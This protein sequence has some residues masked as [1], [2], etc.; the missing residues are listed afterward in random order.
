[1]EPAAQAEKD[2]QKSGSLYGFDMLNYLGAHAAHAH[3]AHAAAVYA[4]THDGQQPL[5][6]AI[7]ALALY[8]R[9]AF[10]AL[11]QR[12]ELALSASAPADDDSALA[13]YINSLG[14]LHIRPR[15]QPRP[16]YSDKDSWIDLGLVPVD[17]ALAAAIN[18]HHQALLQQERQAFGVVRAAMDELS[19]SG[20]LSEVLEQVIDHVDHVE[21]V[22][23]YLDD[24]MFARIDR[25]VNLIDDK[26]GQGY[27]N[28]LRGQP[29]GEWSEGAVLMVAALHALFLSGRSVRF[30]EFNG[31]LLS[32]SALLE[33]LNALTLSYSKAE[34]DTGAEVD[35]E[36]PAADTLALF[37]LA[38][39]IRQQS[40]RATGKSWLRYRTIYG[41]NFM[42]HE[43][44]LASNTSTE[45]PRSYLAEFGADY[46]ELVSAEPG[47]DASEFI[48]M[49]QLASECL[50][51][52]V[53][54]IACDRGSAAV[55][56]WIEYLME[57]IVASAV[58]ATRSD[59]GMSSSLRDLAQ[60]VEY[61]EQRLVETIHGLTPAHF[62][63]CFVASDF[64]PRF[65]ADEGRTIAASVQKR[66][67][68]NRWHFIPG[69]L[70][71]TTIR[72]N[73]HWYYPP[74]VP[75]IAEHADVHR[76]AHARAMVKFSIRSPGPDMS[77]PPLQIAG[78][79]FRGFYDVRVVRM[80]GTPFN[81]DDILR[82]RRR[83]LWLEVVYSILSSYLMSDA[84]QNRAIQGF[85]VGD[86][87]DL[88]AGQSDA[89]DEAL[90]A[91]AL[92]GAR[93][94]AGHASL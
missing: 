4:L 87:L 31:A 3:S 60:M 25:F 62:F 19:R 94:A 74:L 15:S 80:D 36:A 20:E 67:M 56:S 55:T 88:P 13:L 39:H 73:R 18:G 54:G 17:A 59:Y 70:E 51:R 27:L 92:A 64:L 66:M 93:A 23:F 2:K 76:A 69:N 41:L 48:F 38:R 83:T 61:D 11:A 86:Y 42:K 68:F 10:A 43:Q 21:S 28:S 44:I 72:S 89:A 53:A 82:T 8:D 65:G 7:D 6:Q 32:A 35:A 5:D 78:H 16:E 9:A 91:A 49:A 45:D 26:R 1:M 90:L 57:K 30:E 46:R 40:I 24:R 12:R 29:Y 77:R 33:R 75:D 81:T 37:E 47:Y 14:R 84:A 22:C 52:D 34:L 50:A 63:T 79:H 58:L 85:Q 71:R